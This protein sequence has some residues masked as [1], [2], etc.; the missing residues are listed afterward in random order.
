MQKPSN[1]ILWV[2]LSSNLKEIKANIYDK[3]HACLFRNKLY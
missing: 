1:S 2:K 3:E